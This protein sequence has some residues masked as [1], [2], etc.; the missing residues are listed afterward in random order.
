MFYIELIKEDL[1]T[2]AE[3]FGKTKKEAVKHLIEDV[4]DF[5]RKNYKSLKEIRSDNNISDVIIRK[6]D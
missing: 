2:F 6:I 5:Y 3:D 1:L 4:N